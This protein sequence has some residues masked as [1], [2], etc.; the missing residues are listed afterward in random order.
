[1]GDGDHDGDGESSGRQSANSPDDVDIGTKTVR[2]EPGEKS[3]DHHDTAD[4]SSPQSG[5]SNTSTDD[6]ATPDTDTPIVGPGG[7]YADYYDLLGVT[8]SATSR[9][10]THAY[11]QAAKR[12]HPDASDQSEAYAQRTFRE[13]LAAREVLTNWERRRAY[14]QLGHEEFCRQT[15]T[16]EVP[17][18][19][20]GEQTEKT[21]ANR[22][23]SAKIG[24]V[25]RTA[26]GDAHHRG[27]PIV[28]PNEY[29]AAQSTDDESTTD[30]E[31]ADEGPNRG[32]YGLGSD[33]RAYDSTSLSVV[34]T[35]WR[36]SWLSRLLLVCVTPLLGMGIAAGGPVVFD[37]IGVGL[38]VPAATPGRVYGFTLGVV[39]GLALLGSIR[40]EG[41]FPRGAFVEE[42]EDGW[43]APARARRSILL[44]LVALA[45]SLA[46]VLRLAH[47][48]VTPWGHTSERFQG[49]TASMA[50][51]DV[52]AAGL[53]AW[54]THLDVI[55]TIA[56]VV[57]ALG[58]IALV[59]LGTSARCWRARYVD[60]RTVHPS[61]WEPVF[62]IG[63][64][65]MGFAVVI[66]PV[67]LPMAVESQVA[68]LPES[69]VVTLAID[70]GQITVATVA[71][72]STAVACCLTPMLWLRTRLATPSANWI[73][74]GD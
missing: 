71:V 72:L 65:S 2:R 49:T 26:R 57:T 17:T 64:V 40:I 34:T 29:P 21:D 41:Q 3:S 25:Q 60:G 33:G 10:I 42:R 16:G 51:F 20:D 67:G 37:R 62:L 48:G 22:D 28:P 1:M 54:S 35:R 15:A 43:F 73:I 8:S 9:R 12:H 61:L 14:D 44:G 74:A 63:L 13:V 68:S 7:E 18:V 39:L 56:F 70:D 58:G 59:S 47:G 32:I 45:S 24:R 53:A 50:W 52:E 69:L 5:E 46:L 6:A 38:S 36:R 55:V 11:R 31:T 27:E 4:T 30:S 19:T 66:G 23:G